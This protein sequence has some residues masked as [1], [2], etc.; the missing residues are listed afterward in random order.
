MDP[1]GTDS[2][3]A[4]VSRGMATLAYPKY[5]MGGTKLGD[6]LEALTKPCWFADIRISYDLS[7]LPLC[8]SIS[9]SQLW[10]GMSQCPS[11]EQSQVVP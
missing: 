1:N 6:V 2:V 4:P 3:D 5:C 11:L 7:E 8:P 9:L 10:P